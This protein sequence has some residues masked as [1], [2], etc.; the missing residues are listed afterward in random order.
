LLLQAYTGKLANID[1]DVSKD[2]L[3]KTGTLKKITGGDRIPGEFKFKPVFYFKNRAKMI[4]SANVIPDTEDD[5]DALHSRYEIVNYPNQY[6]DDKADPYLIDK[7]TTP[8]EMSALLT[9]LL[10]RL[11]RVLQTGISSKSTIEGNY[12]KYKESADPIGL[13]KELAIRPADANT[14]PEDVTKDK[15]YAAYGDFCMEKNLPKESS[16]YFSRELSK[17]DFHYKLKKIGGNSTYVWLD[18][19]LI[20]WRQVDDEGQKTL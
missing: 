16:D 18:I 9:L 19:K 20:N 6:L 15:V 17:L 13:F 12:V 2:E 8:Q 5:T 11:P 3:K 4:F 14:K 10:K 7:L 1:A